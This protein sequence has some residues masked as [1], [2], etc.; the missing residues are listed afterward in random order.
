LTSGRNSILFPPMDNSISATVKRRVARAKPGTFL[1]V[2]DLSVNN[3]SRHAVEHAL[4]RLAAADAPIV[5]AHKGLYF[6]GNESRFGK[7]RPRP[8]DV[9]LE[10]SRNRG[11]GPAGWTALRS[12]GVTTQVPSIDEVALLGAPPTG[13]DGVRFHVRR[14]PAR[15]DLTLHEIATLEAVRSWPTHVGSDW[16]ELRT[17][18]GGLVADGRI[19]PTRLRKAACSEPV[20]VRD[21]LD[22]LLTPTAA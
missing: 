17:A 11:A 10:V 21:K 4:S 5:R 6:R 22:T 13:I 14:N 19:R 7:T 8:V 9:A 2:S 20:R 12:L 16:S 3:G 1:R 18:I 15:L